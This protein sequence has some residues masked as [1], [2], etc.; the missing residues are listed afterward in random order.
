MSEPETPEKCQRGA[1]AKATCITLG[2]QGSRFPEHLNLCATAWGIAKEAQTRE[3]IARVLYAQDS[4]A[5]PVFYAQEY[6][7]GVDAVLVALGERSC[8]EC[9]GASRD[10]DGNESRFACGTCSAALKGEPK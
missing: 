8:P 10:A 3:R 9:A 2:H 5:G 1:F 7:D 6:A 4:D